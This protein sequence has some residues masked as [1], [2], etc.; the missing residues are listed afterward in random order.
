VFCFKNNFPKK[1]NINVFFQ[2]KNE[3]SKFF[4]YTKTK[5]KVDLDLKNR[6]LLFKNRQLCVA[7]LASKLG[8]FRSGFEKKVAYKKK[9][10][11]HQKVP[12]VTHS[13]VESKA[14][15]GPQV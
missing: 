10:V 14:A 15:A 8:N 5:K 4:W 13:V 7:I 3:H 9:S 11:L 6:Q 1:Y 2:E 12:R